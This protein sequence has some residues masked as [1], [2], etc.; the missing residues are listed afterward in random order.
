MYKF[1]DREFTQSEIDAGISKLVEQIENGADWD[2]DGDY[3]LDLVTD[4]LMV[5]FSKIDYQ[6]K[7]SEIRFMIDKWILI[8]ARNAV[9]GNPK[10][11]CTF[12]NP[13]DDL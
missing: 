13:N 9:T 7:Y 8:W 1:E 4:I 10:K 6:D 2:E 3:R 12:I 11:Y 5:N